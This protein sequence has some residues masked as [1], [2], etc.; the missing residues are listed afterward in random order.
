MENICYDNSSVWEKW[1]YSFEMNDKVIMNSDLRNF[2]DLV[3]RQLVLVDI[4]KGKFG[5]VKKCWSDLHAFGFGSMYFC[6]VDFDGIIINAFAG[7]FVK[8]F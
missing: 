8:H 2:Y 6:T 5:V 4:L 7:A 1:D 3:S